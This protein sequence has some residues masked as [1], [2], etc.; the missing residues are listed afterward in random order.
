MVGDDML[1]ADDH[2]DDDDDDDADGDDDN[3]D[4]GDGDYDEITGENFRRSF[5]NG[6]EWKTSTIDSHSSGLLIKY[7]DVIIPL[8]IL[9]VLLFTLI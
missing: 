1:F 2:E 4:E 8:S 6:R 7:D 9:F 5:P 3:D